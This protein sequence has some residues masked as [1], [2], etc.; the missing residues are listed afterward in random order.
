MIIHV[1]AIEI[2]ITYNIMTS[3]ANVLI[4]LYLSIEGDETCSTDQLTF[5]EVTQAVHSSGVQ[6]CEWQQ[7]FTCLVL[8]VH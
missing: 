5:T 4:Y 3:H 8:S 2:Q 7:P 1:F 6:G